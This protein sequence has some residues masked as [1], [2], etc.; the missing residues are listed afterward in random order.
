MAADTGLNRPDIVG[1]LGG[2][3]PLATVDFMKK[4]VERTPATADQD[5]VP[6]IVCSCPQIPD[7]VAPAMGKSA[8]SPLPAL[9][10]RLKLL[11]DAGARCIA[12]PCNTAHFWYDA[13]AAAARPVPF[14]HIADATAAELRR[15]GVAPAPVVLLGTEGMFRAGFYQDRLG[16]AGFP[17][18]LPS[19]DILREL[20]LPGIASVKRNR[21]VDAEGLF[22]RAVTRATE[23]TGTAVAVLACTEIPA[24]LSDADP[25]VAAHTVDP[26]DALARAAVD[27][28]MGARRE[29]AAE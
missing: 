20:V 9:L 25:W 27:W 15:R 5:H 11:L 18:A 3:G 4:V 17:C 12:M 7:R 13:L 2:M 26:N 22:R 10:D 8:P 19:A 29:M 6:L 28:A 1:V 16:K 23:E 14:I 24:A 21:L